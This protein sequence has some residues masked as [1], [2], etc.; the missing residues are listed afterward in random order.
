MTANNLPR[1][2]RAFLDAVAQGESDPTAKAE[3][4]SPYFILYG[5]GSFET[6]PN[7]EGY[8]G[9][10]SWAGKDN[11][12]AAGRYQF[13]PA[14]WRGIVP[15]F[16]PGTPD[17]RNP[18]DQDWGAWFLAQQDYAVR[19]TSP[20]YQALQAGSL[21]SIGSTLQ[22][23][24]TSLSDS[25]FPDRYTAALANYPV[26]APPVVVPVPPVPSIPTWPKVPPV[27]PS[28]PTATS[29]GTPDALDIAIRQLQ[30]LFSIA[31]YYTGP[32][33]G[34]PNDG[35]VAGLQS[36][37]DYLDQNASSGS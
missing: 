25:T 5:G 15:R 9:F 31:G 32:I 22:P 11:S 13:E 24:W 33:D 23:T 2:A 36:Y 8:N 26:V 1:E 29:L 7:R 20:L 30:V 34:R 37:L 21:D 10:P 6:F 12:H 14:T 18:D 19:A 3:G 17:F 27:I 4:I 16:K 35:V 28:I